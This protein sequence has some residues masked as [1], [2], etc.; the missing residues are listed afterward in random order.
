MTNNLIS[1]LFKTNAVR[2]CQPDSPFWYTSNKIGPYYVNTH[3]LYGSEDKAND[4]LKVIDE[5]KLNQD[6]CT[7][8]VYKEVKANYESDDIYKD[9]I[10]S[11][12]SFVKS[13]IDLD[14]IDFISGG[15]R[16]GWDH[17]DRNFHTESGTQSGRTGRGTEQPGG[18][19]R[20]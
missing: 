14:N 2:I 12:V 5:A 1:N 6:S 8:I 15:E 7:E 17:H 13:N 11:M 19:C 20:V 9:L 10:D 16:R 3:F 4:L 18:R